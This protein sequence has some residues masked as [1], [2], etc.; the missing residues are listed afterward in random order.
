MKAWK[1]EDPWDDE[2]H[3]EIV[4]AAT[5]SEA[6]NNTSLDI[7]FLSRRATRAPEFDGL[8]GDDLIRAQLAAGWWFGCMG[9]DRQVRAEEGEGYDETHMAAPYVLRDGDVYCSAKC[10][11]KRLRGDR[12]QRMR[13]WNA[14]KVVTDRY[15]GSN[16]LRIFAAL[17]S[18]TVQFK[19]PG[20][21]Y[22]VGW[23]IGEE[24]VQVLE[25]DVEA[26]ERFAAPLREHVG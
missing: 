18:V 4:H 11:L 24:E 5:R 3:A 21:K 15:P 8:A 1:I 10:C 14:A 20:G 2:G 25:E 22:P 19:F 12:E 9:C 13:I 7:E 17:R 16:E 6:K 23:T 26:W